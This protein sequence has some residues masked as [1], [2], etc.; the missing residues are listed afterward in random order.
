MHVRLHLQEISLQRTHPSPQGLSYATFIFTVVTNGC[1]LG[2]GGYRALDAL[3]IRPSVCHMNE[4][5]GERIRQLMMETNIAFDDA[6]EATSA[7]NIFTEE[8]FLG[9]PLGRKKFLESSR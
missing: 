3:G 8:K 5:H 1:V 2:I 9:V 4:G 7:G 6:C